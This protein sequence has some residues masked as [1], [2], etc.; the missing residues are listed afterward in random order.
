MN[1]DELFMKR[2]IQIARCGEAG[3]A[4]NPMV[5][6]VIV[7]QGRI[8]GEG[9]H[10]KYGGPHAEVN[11]INSVQDSKLLKDSTIYVTL[12]PCSHW[13]KTPPCCDLIIDQGFRRV[14]VGMQDP[15]QKV[16]GQGIERIRQAGI[17]VKVGVLQDECEALNS[18]FLTFHRRKRPF[19]TLKWAQTS[20]GIIG[21]KS[22]IH[23]AENQ[24][25]QTLRISTQM[26]RMLVHRLRTRVQAIM[27]GTETALNDNP[28]LTAR[29][30][31]GPSPL[32]ITIDRHGRLGKD[33]KMLTS[34]PETIVYKN[35][36]LG[37][38]M[39]DL[40]RRGIQ[41]LMVEGGR[42]LLES[43]INEGLWDEARVEYGNM[44]APDQASLD[45][46][47]ITYAPIL[48]TAKISSETMIDGHKVLILLNSQPQ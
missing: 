46:C 6:A 28:E 40:H 1:Q 35:Q 36:I 32:R 47:R 4:P 41:H 23:D 5:G 19:I 10:R 38:I 20:D 48:R 14:V 43:F 44:E 12:E 27:V 22:N 26:N 37:E 33:L 18:S 21:V 7:Y 29:L 42:K 31:D 9:Y 30:W 45:A 39:Y 11:A 3:T 13:G 25:P 15:N 8:I 17:Q 16:N 34:E 24:N 2:A